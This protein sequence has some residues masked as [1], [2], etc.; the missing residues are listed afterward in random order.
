MCFGAGA[1]LVQAGIA[2]AQGDHRGATLAAVG[3]IPGGKLI[4][5][6]AKVLDAVAD[7]GRVINKLGDAGNATKALNRTVGPCGLCFA[8]GTKVNTPGGQIN[9]E[10]LRVGDKVRSTLLD[11]TKT[12]GW[13]AVKAATWRLIKLRMPNPDDSSDVYEIELLRPLDWIT[14]TG[15]VKGRT[16]E[17]EFPE[18]DLRG[19]AGVIDVSTCPNIKPGPGRVVLS[20]LT[21]RSPQLM[22]IKVEGLDQ[23][24]EPTA[25]HPFFS[26][27]RR[28]WVL[29]RELR[30]GEMVRTKECPARIT[31][32]KWKA[33]TYRVYN[34][35][36]EADHTYFVAKLGIL[37]H[38]TCGG[39]APILKGQKGVEQVKKSIENSGGTVLGEQVSVKVSSGTARPDLYVQT[40]QGE[41]VFVEVKT[42][43]KAKL[44]KEQQARLAEI[45]SRGG[46]GVGKRAAD[47]DLTGR[48][49]P[50]PVVVVRVF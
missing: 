22:E 12:D 38:N 7:G 42:G 24:I 29:A 34:I 33:G 8:E 10:E 40:A 16:L 26:E 9:I 20:T 14:K 43:P 6:G 44:S 41:K 11:Y 47:A 1:S 39:R 48:I 2:V 50:T 27:D 4:A 13:T 23:V 17:V 5:K 35:E 15:A 36:V 19:R 49:K 30:V 46:T 25:T 18:L 31:E 3:A 37:V 28:G 45:Q 32:I 21:H